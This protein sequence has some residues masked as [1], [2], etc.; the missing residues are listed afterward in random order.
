MYE[1]A[2]EELTSNLDCDLKLAGHHQKYEC[3]HDDRRGDVDLTLRT[4]D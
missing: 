4:L 1:I 2:K 3:C